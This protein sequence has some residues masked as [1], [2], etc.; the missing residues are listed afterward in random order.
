M[1]AVYEA[2]WEL[3]SHE[4][5]ENHFIMDTLKARLQSR[6]V[7]NEAV[8]NCHEDS[9]LLEVIGLVERVYTA[10]TQKERCKYGQQLQRKIRAFL[11]DFVTHME[12]EEAV[13]QPLLDQNFEPQELQQMNEKVVVTT[14]SYNY[15]QVVQGRIFTRRSWSSTTFTERRSKRRT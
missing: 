1:Q 13:F 15:L 12:Q 10:R 6:Q 11:D 9:M 8:C 5:I 2:M 3:K 14:M 4:Y 7:F